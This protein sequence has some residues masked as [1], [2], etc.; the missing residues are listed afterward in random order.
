MIRD[1]VSSEQRMSAI[2]DIPEE[3]II[4]GDTYISMMANTAYNTTLEVLPYK[5]GYLQSCFYYTIYD[6]YIEIYIEDCDYAYY[7]DVDIVKT[8]GY[9]MRA[10]KT[11]EKSFLSDYSGANDIV[12]SIS[13]RY[14]PAYKWS[15][16]QERIL[17]MLERIDKKI[18]K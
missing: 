12:D 5:S 6:T 9:W 1:V 4:A 13:D 14:G 8:M 15:I 3:Y 18:K 2:I 10:C 11:F 16:E 7:L 17:K